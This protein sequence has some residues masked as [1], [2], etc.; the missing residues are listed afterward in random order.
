MLVSSKFHFTLPSTGKID[1]IASL[2]ASDSSQPICQLQYNAAFDC[3]HNK[4]IECTIRRNTW[5][6]NRFDI[7]SKHAV[8]SITASSKFLVL[9]T[10]YLY[11]ISLIK[12]IVNFELCYLKVLGSMERFLIFRR[13]NI[14]YFL[15]NEFHCTFS[16]SYIYY[17]ILFMKDFLC[18]ISSVLSKVISHGMWLLAWEFLLYFKGMD[19]QKA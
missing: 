18:K 5:R 19:H 6:T 9:N 11:T 14:F 1:K 13:S 16:I 17:H 15:L 4:V 2:Y 7:D 12:F 8:D 3:Q 10:E